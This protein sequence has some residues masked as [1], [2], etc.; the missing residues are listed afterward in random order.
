MKGSTFTSAANGVRC[1]VTEVLIDDG[2]QQ[3]SG[4]R[5]ESAGKKQWRRERLPS[6][7]SQEM[8]VAIKKNAKRLWLSLCAEWVWP[9]SDLPGCRDSLWPLFA[10]FCAMANPIEEMRRKR[11]LAWEKERARDAA[12]RGAPAPS[13]PLAAVQ[14]D[15]VNHLRQ[16]HRAVTLQELSKHVG[17]DV[18]AHPE[19]LE[20]L[21]VHQR[22]KVLP[23]GLYAYRARYEVANAEEMF[24][25]IDSS[26]EGIVAVELAESYHDAERDA[27][28]LVD[29]GRVLVFR[30]KQLGSDVLFGRYA[31]FDLK[32]PQAL[33][34]GWHSINIQDVNKMVADLQA[35]GHTVAVP[36]VPIKPRRRS[37]KVAKK[38]TGR[39]VRDPY[40]QHV[41][42]A[43]RNDDWKLELAEDA[44]IYG[45]H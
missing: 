3:R 32:I 16:A 19:L 37:K 1:G 17:H 28:K 40:N 4:A 29:E 15:V 36:P 42:D 41:P 10:A 2:E 25:L 8:C 7:H 33:K 43:Y 34:D 35:K 14:R 45:K 21:R 39:Q 27:K 9:L 44:Q 24:A 23:G 13:I 22:I 11:E 26:P 38:S 12:K 18:G 5:E 6:R 20:S 31:E 30:N